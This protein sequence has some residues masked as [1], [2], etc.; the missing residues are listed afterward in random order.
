MQKKSSNGGGWLVVGAVLLAG[1]CSLKKDEPAA[2][3]STIATYD[4]PLDEA[5]ATSIE[6]DDQQDANDREEVFG[7]RVIAGETYPQ[8]DERRDAI[9][10]G[11]YSAGEECTEDCSGHDAGRQWAERRGVTS[12][13]DCGGKSWSFVEGCRSYADEQSGSGS[14]A[15]DT[16]VG[17]F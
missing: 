10:T 7:G 2:T 15:S 14:D 4:S 1:Y 5:D 11:L 3:A 6:T 17:D 8:Y 9:A 16:E 13:D 12:A